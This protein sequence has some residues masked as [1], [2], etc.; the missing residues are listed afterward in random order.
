MASVK[1]KRVPKNT[2]KSWRKNV[3]VADVEDFL[4][5]QRLEERLG[6]KV[7]DQ[8]NDELFSIDTSGAVENAL[9]K[10][11][12]VD[13]KPR[14]SMRLKEDM[15]TKCYS[16]LD[17]RSAVPDPISK[18]NHVKQKPKVQKPLLGRKKVNLF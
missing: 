7:R 14:K 12:I 9:P 10:T 11:T 2:K 4:E 16:I 3:D 8:S 6:V 1:R 5:D 13:K 18:R 17:K 15:N